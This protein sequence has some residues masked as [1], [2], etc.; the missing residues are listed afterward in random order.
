MLTLTSDLLARAK[1]YVDADDIEVGGWLTDTLWYQW[2]NQEHRSLYRALIRNGLMG[3]IYVDQDVTADGSEFHTLAAEPL[4]ISGVAEMVGGQYPRPLAP[5]QV[6]RGRYPW[7]NQSPTLGGAS[8][9]WTAYYASNGT[10][11]IGFQPVPATG[12]YRIRVVPAPLVLMDTASITNSATQT[13]TVSFPHGTEERIA[14]GMAERAY[15]REGV[16]SPSLGRLIQ[17][18]DEEMARAAGE[19]LE[20]QAPKVRNVDYEFRGWRRRGQ[21]QSPVMWTAAPQLW[22]WAP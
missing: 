7:A 13:D 3:P 1:A 14:L 21:D 12:T 19:L 11:Q 22:W 9:H 10:V 16:M 2:M 17:R 5:M 4:A 8:T 20:G 18:A 15:E 6:L